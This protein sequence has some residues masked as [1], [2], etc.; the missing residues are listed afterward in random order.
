MNVYAMLVSPPR[1]ISAL[2]QTYVLLPPNSSL[3]DTTHSRVRLW[4]AMAPL[5]CWTTAVSVGLA[6]SESISSKH[7][8]E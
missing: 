7:D 3:P 2:L 8:W 5:W 6:E 1:T 4:P